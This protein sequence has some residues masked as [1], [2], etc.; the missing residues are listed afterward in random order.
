M[1]ERS[2]FSA[3]RFLPKAGPPRILAV[4]TLVTTIGNGAFLTCSVLYF[5]TFAGL[6]PAQLGLGLTLA[7]IAGLFAGVPFGHLSD[8]YGPRGVAT[9]LTFGGG[10]ATAAYLTVGDFWTFLL[11]AVVF[12]VCDRGNRAATQAAVAVYVPAEQLVETR[13][14]LRA[15]TN[16]GISIGT[17]LAGIALQA[18][19]RN[20]YLVVFALD[21]LS[22]FACAIVLLRLP[23]SVNTRPACS[24]GSRFAVL[25]DR[26]FVAMTA[27]NTVM[28]LHFALLEVALPLWIVK[29]THAP[30]SLLSVL[31]LVNT[32]AVVLFQVRLARGAVTM[33]T[34][35]RTFRRAGLVLLLACVLFAA[36]SGG[37][38]VTAT[39]LLLLAAG[40]HVYGEMIQSAA[41]WTIS[42]TLSPADQQGQYQGLFQTGYGVSMMLAPLILTTL[43]IQWGAP[44][45]FV[46]AGLFAA[47]GYVMTPVVRW[48]LRSSSATS[49]A[50]S[51]DSA[52]T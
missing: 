2:R 23:R 22:F 21:A 50:P 35:V 26:P 38:P 13:A 40:A 14:Y 15:V 11:A 33:D 36:S 32:V 44:G 18:G 10:V 51:L 16:V 6:S 1:S 24:G 5:T 30:H 48:A 31:I 49:P 8:R 28:M 12:T 37:S 29:H 34:A 7:G 52:V 17:G 41:A 25:R 47:S 20:V 39:V 19:S 4:A 27:V 9:A 3:S 42:F 46:L 43:V 45:W